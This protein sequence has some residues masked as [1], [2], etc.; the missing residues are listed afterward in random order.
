MNIVKAIKEKWLSFKISR[1]I[2]KHNHNEYFKLVKKRA[3]IE[4]EKM[5]AE[6]MKI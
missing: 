6:K 1:A 4:A 5:V 2:K 3:I